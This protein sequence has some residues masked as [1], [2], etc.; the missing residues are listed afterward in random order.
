MESRNSQEC[1][2]ANRETF[3]TDDQPAVHLLTPGKGPLGLETRHVDLDGSAPRFLGLPDPFG[4]HAWRPRVR[5]CRR[6]SVA[7]TPLSG[8][9][10]FGRFQGRPRVPVRGRSASNSGMTWAR[11]VPLAGVVRCARGIPA[12]SVRLW[13]RGHLPLPPRAT[14]S[15]PPV[16]GANEPSTAPCCQ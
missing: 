4:I 2:E 1:R 12:A 13:V 15:P 10:T 3:P 16:P 9:I 6:R 5:S 11:S 8:A 14:L 7:S